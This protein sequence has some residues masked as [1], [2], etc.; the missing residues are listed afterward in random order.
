L[1]PIPSSATHKVIDYKIGRIYLYTQ[2][3]IYG[4]LW[5][6]SHFVSLAV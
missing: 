2:I 4:F 1:C 5:F 3:E 6:G